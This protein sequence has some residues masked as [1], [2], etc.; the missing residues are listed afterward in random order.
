MADRIERP[1][2]Y[3][4]Q[5][6]GAADLS[7]GVEHARGRSARHD[8]YLHLWG[9]AEGLVLTGKEKKTATDQEYQEVAVSAGMAIDGTG[10]E[11]V[12][13]EPEILSEDL[14]SQ[15]QLTGGISNED[16]KKTWFPVFLRGGDS[17]APLSPVMAGSCNGSGPVRK[18][19]DFEITFGRPGSERDQDDESE[20]ADGPGDR[21]WKIL[22]GFIQW[23]RDISKF[24]AAGLESEGSRPRY[25]GVQADEVA[26]RGGQLMLH[27]RTEKEAGKPALVL[28][29][30]EDGTL[31][32]GALNPLGTVEPVFKVNAKGDLKVEGKISSAVL[33]GTMQ[34]QTG[35]V[36]DGLLLPLPPGIDPD[37]IE[38]GKVT[39]F[40]HVTPHITTDQAPDTASTWGVVPIECFVDDDRRVRCLLRWFKIGGT[41][42]DIVD[43]AGLSDYISIVS[44][45]AATGGAS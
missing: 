5:V 29:E 11:I 15:L 12:V 30:E 6:L 34:V 22:I 41:S 17:A 43:Q 4:G 39:L 40:S 18:V 21:R 1:V 13:P 36:M 31:L 20:I 23:R 33:P 28:N 3:E 42:T 44:I 14:F 7:A 38:E 27:T 9:I 25:A 2:F 32:F 45:P 8:R 26:A 24:T 35:V 37:D 16:L 19:E 10:R